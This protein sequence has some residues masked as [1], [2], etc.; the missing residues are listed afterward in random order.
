MSK[1]PCA[2]LYIIFKI[3]EFNGFHLNVNAELNYNCITELN[4]NSIALK[5]ACKVKLQSLKLK[6]LI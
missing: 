6:N 3:S 5:Y 2:F 1:F 4:D